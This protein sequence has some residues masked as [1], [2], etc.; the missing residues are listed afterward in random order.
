M[1][2]GLLW[3]ARGRLAREESERSGAAGNGMELVVV[4]AVVERGAV[5][6]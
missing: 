2:R 1:V 3:C 6:G 5:P 4:A